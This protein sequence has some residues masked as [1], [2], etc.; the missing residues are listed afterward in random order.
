[1]NSVPSQHHTDRQELAN[2]LNRISA[3]EIDYAIELQSKAGTTCAIEFMKSRDLDP[4]LI[5]RVLAHPDKRR[6]INSNLNVM[7]D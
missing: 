1:M 4:D 6:P 3:A 7:L 5:F 2:R